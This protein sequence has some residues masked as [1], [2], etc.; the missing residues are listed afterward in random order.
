MRYSPLLRYNLACKPHAGTSYIKGTN[1]NL[2]A[3]YK[4]QE[5]TKLTNLD[6]GTTVNVGKIN[7]GI[8]A[9][10]CNLSFI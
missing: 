4:L 2:E 7:G 10:T 1:A 8:G 3:S 5:L 9:G 6:I